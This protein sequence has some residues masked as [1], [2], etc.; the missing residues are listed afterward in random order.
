MGRKKSAL[1]KE[2]SD[3][4]KKNGIEQMYL[5]GSRASGKVHKDS[6]VDLIVVSKRFRGKGLLGRAPPLY[7]K[8]DIHY[9]VDFLCYTPQ[10]FNKLKK[11][12]TIVREA[13]RNGIKI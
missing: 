12:I 8:W 7:I 1:L 13:V 10:E 2:L 9:P 3:F 5:F 11:Q 4:K 6:D